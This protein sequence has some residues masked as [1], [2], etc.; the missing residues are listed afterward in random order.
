M[1]AKQSSIYLSEAVRTKLR[2]PPRGQSAAVSATID[3]YYALLAPERKRL[4]A[5]FS[6][7]EWNAMRNACNGTLWD[8]ASIRGGV[9]A[10]IQDSLEDELTSFGADRKTL[11]KKLADLAPATQYALVEMLEEYWEAYGPKEE[12]PEA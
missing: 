11:E 6:S 8:A 3:R 1:A 4:E 5:L 10:N 2:T 7:S 12:E 9:L